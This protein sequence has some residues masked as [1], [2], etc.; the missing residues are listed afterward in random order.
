MNAKDL[1]HTH[2]GYWGKYPKLSISSWQQDV[3]G[4]QTRH[5]YW[6]WVANRLEG[7]QVNQSRPTRRGSV[8]I[9]TIM[10]EEQ[11]KLQG[12]NPNPRFPAL[13]LNQETFQT[14]S[15]INGWKRIRNNKNEPTWAHFTR[16]EMDFQLEPEK[17]WT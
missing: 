3:V 2:G 7:R 17:N 5:G 8:T 11:A 13:A 12:Y 1:M 16:G 10:S 6:E 9:G 15:D 14:G 4:N